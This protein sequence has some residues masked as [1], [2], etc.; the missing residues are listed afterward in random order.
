[1]GSITT[2]VL[3]V[4]VSTLACSVSVSSM[5][6]VCE[7]AATFWVNNDV[8]KI[9][10]GRYSVS[11]SEQVSCQWVFKAT[12]P[13]LPIHLEIRPPFIKHSREATCSLITTVKDGDT[14]LRTFC[15]R[16]SELKRLYFTGYSGAMTVVLESNI[17]TSA[18]MKSIKIKFYQDRNDPLITTTAATATTTKRPTTTTTARPTTT[19]TASATT[20][21]SFWPTT[22]T[23]AASKTTTS[24]SFWPTTT[25]TA[26]SRTRTST[27]AWSTTTAT[28]TT[29]SDTVTMCGI[30]TLVA[31]DRANYIYPYTAKS[32]CQ[33]F[34]RASNPNRPIHL[35]IRSVSGNTMVCND[36][37]VIADGLQIIPRHCNG[38]TEYYTSTEDTMTVFYNHDGD[39]LS[40]SQISIIYYQEKYYQEKYHDNDLLVRH[41]VTISSVIG[42]IVLVLLVVI[43]ITALCCRYRR[44]RSRRSANRTLTMAVISDAR[45]DAGPPAYTD[46]FPTKKVLPQSK[47]KVTKDPSL[48]QPT[49]NPLPYYSA[50]TDPALVDPAKSESNI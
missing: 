7:D 11:P 29:T 6:A 39:V 31:S 22:T 18:T 47:D 26:A 49:K 48:P 35:E 24:T 21:T 40:T 9:K 4:I 37:L 13:R 10:S 50:K 5:R 25:T 23:T 14:V 33:W 44:N 1:M 32:Y 15:E 27:S 42:A 16:Q 38:S 41:V 12:N 30:S 3:L 43:L 17:Q 28:T 19:K 8:Q 36:Q 45:T 2:S 20:S 46:L 34:I